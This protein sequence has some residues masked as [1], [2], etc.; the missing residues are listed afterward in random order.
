VGLIAP[1][2][3]GIPLQMA[4]EA[5]AGND[6]RVLSLTKTQENFEFV[7]VPRSPVP[8]CCADFPRR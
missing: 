1:D 8:S 4:G 6:T 2:G 3:S 5:K 7:N